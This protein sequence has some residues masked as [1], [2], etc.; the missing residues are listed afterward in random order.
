MPRIERILI[1]GAGLAGLSLAIALKRH[2][3]IPDIVERHPAWPVHG[4]GI[5]LVGNAMRALQSLDL[6]DDVL[7]RGTHIRKQALLTDRGRRLATID[8]ESVWRNCGRV[9]GSDALISRPH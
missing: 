2:G 5:Y 3:L 6:A 8:T 7:H 1:V 9:L 4:A